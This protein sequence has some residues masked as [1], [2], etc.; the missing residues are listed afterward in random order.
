VIILGKTFKK[1]TKEE[2]RMLLD[3]ITFD[4]RGYMN[5]GKKLQKLLGMNRKRVNARIRYLRRSGILPDIYYDDP[6]APILDTFTETEDK[7][8]INMIKQGS[9]GA[10]IAD[11]LG[12]KYSSVVH[13]ARKL[14]KEGKLKHRKRHVYTNEEIQF[15]LSEVKFDIYGYVSN[16]KQ[17]ARALNLSYKQTQ[18][19]IWKLR[20]QGYINIFPDRTKVSVNSSEGLKAVT[21]IWF[22][23]DTNRMKYY[24]R[25]QKEK[26]PTS[27]TAE[28]SKNKEYI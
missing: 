15:V 2:T 3:N 27:D 20:K 26:K 4:E 16:T 24:A 25:K 5:N 17:M 21:D 6:I 14:R 11:A 23:I 19:I 10:E 18:H 12:K 7:I 13:R 22:Q 28:I 9:R 8:L 1:W